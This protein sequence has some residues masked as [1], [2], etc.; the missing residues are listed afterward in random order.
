MRRIAI[1]VAAFAMLAGQTALARSGS[2]GGHAG[3]VHGLGNQPTLT[4]SARAL[5]V[6]S[7][8]GLDNTN[9]PMAAERKLGRERAT[10]RMS[11]PG[12]THGKASLPVPD[13]RHQPPE[14]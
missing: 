2:A 13:R 12:R 14:Q 11:E 8:R 9:G 10:V 1:I 6:M 4:G 5:E 3:A 7:P